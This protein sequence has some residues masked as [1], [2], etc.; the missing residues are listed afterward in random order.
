MLADSPDL[1]LTYTNGDPAEL[2][3]MLTTIRR[4]S[5]ADVIVPTLHLFERYTLSEED[6]ER[7]VL[8]WKAVREVCRRHQLPDTTSLYPVCSSNCSATDATSASWGSSIS[9]TLT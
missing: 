5:T 1:I 2:D 6:V 3:K 4:R 8:D 7:G 9:V